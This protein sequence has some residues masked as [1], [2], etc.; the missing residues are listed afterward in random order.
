MAEADR[1]GEGPPGPGAA[2][3]GGADRGRRERPG[4]RE[5]VPGVADAGEPVVAGAGRRRET[6]AGLQGAGGARCKLTPVQLRELEAVLNAGP[7]SGA[8][9]PAASSPRPGSTS[10]FRDLPD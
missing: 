2:G 5:T 10:P 3:G 6:S 9:S 1:A 4:G 8:V 7:P